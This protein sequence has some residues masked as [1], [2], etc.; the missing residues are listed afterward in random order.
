MVVDLFTGSKEF[1]LSSGRVIRIPKFGDDKML[2]GSGN[3]PG[4]RLNGSY[5]GVGE[6][7]RRRDEEDVLRA[8]LVR[9][10]HK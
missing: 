2:C 1:S 4:L 6:S 10:K 8:E 9:R 7:R 5:G 3:M